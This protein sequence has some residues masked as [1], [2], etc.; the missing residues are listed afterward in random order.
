V[1]EIQSEGN[2]HTQVFVGFIRREEGH[3]VATIPKFVC[4]AVLEQVDLLLQTS[5]KAS[6]RSI[7]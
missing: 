1:F 4:E 2:V 3:K 7:V 5:G 6:V